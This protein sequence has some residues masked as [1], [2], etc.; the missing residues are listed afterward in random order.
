MI[1]IYLLTLAGIVLGQILPGPNLLAVAGAAL[2]QGR[3]AAMFVALGVATAIFAW[4]A[5]AAFGLG[6]LL[7]VFPALLT[8]M[9]LIGG[10]Y[11]CFL[12]LKA[13][14]SAARGDAAAFGATH[15][16]WSARQAWRHGLL[17]NITNPKSALMWGAVATF[18]F[19]SGLSPLQVLGFAPLGFMSA[20][21]VYSIYAML[22]SSSTARGS[23]GRF[24]RH[25]Q[26][27]FGLAFGAIGGKLVADG[28]SEIFKR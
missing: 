15:A 18:L 9:K 14:R 4:V 11:L 24:A 1:E 22:F 27:L 16:I 7:A 6:A 17:V 5:L 12:A 19:G 3:K 8:A 26:A 28:C 23:Y 13:F 25:V 21:T 10:A 20:L 2:G